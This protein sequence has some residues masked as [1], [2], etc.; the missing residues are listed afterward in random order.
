[1][2]NSLLA[3]AVVFA[4]SS[5]FATEGYEKKYFELPKSESADLLKETHSLKLESEASIQT[6]PQRNDLVLNLFGGLTRPRYLTMS[7]NG[8]TANYDFGAHNALAL[9][10][11][12]LSFYPFAF[13]WGKVGFAASVGYTY[14][15]YYFTAPTA[16]HILP[17]EFD[18]AY[19]ADMRSTQWVIPYLN[20]GPQAWAVFQRGADQYNNSQLYKTLAATAG[21]AFNLSRLGIYK[22]RN[23]MEIVLQ[24]KRTF[25]Q[26]TDAYDLTSNTYQLGG[27]VS[28]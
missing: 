2:K 16:L 5:A 20:V 17:L 11:G 13:K 19:R 26:T 8:V 10:S 15:E 21:V 14:S 4:C 3:V 24:Y 28:L 1:M 18:V 12:Q 9:Y 6:Q 27:A 22:A 7:G 25:S 23:E